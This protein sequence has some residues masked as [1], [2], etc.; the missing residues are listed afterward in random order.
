MKN[1]YRILGINIDAENEEIKAAYRILAQ[2]FHPDKGGKHSEFLLI[3]E[4]YEILSNP[5]TKKNYDH[6]LENYLKHK[7]PLTKNSAK[8][9]EFKLILAIAIA[10]A[11]LIF[12]ITA[13]YYTETRN[14]NIIQPM[15]RLADNTHLD[16]SIPDSSTAL[17]IPT[18]PV[19]SAGTQIQKSH[20]EQQKLTGNYYLINLGSYATYA[21]AKSQQ[22]RLKDQGI[23]TIIQ[24]INANSEGT[25]SY[26]LFI[27]PIQNYESAYQMQQKLESM[28]ISSDINQVSYD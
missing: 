25:T 22:Q 13:Y 26:N 17:T 3:Q 5:R 12:M 10:S 16:A 9:I 27:K 7:Q 2:H 4:A 19:N 24:K 21:A 15:T 1:Y 18:H 20:N 8:P 23:S 11:G 28:N 14:I 6:D